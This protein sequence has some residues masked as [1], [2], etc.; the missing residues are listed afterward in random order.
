[1]SNSRH[2][3]LA[4]SGPSV[5]CVLFCLER[6][7]ENKSILQTDHE[8][9]YYIR[10]KWDSEWAVL[11]FVCMENEKGSNNGQERS[12]TS[13]S[14]RLDRIM[15]KLEE[16]NMLARARY[17]NGVTPIR[18]D[19]IAQIPISLL[20]GVG[21]SEKIPVESAEPEK[22]QETNPESWLQSFPMALAAEMWRAG[23][24]AR[25]VAA[26]LNKRGYVSARGVLITAGALTN[27]FRNRH[28]N[29]QGRPRYATSSEIVAFLDERTKDVTSEMRALIARVALEEI[30]EIKKS[31]KKKGWRIREEETKKGIEESVEVRSKRLADEIAHNARTW[32]PS[33]RGHPMSH[34]SEIRVSQIRTPLLQIRDVSVTTRVD[35]VTK[36]ESYS[37][38]GLDSVPLILTLRIVVITSTSKIDMDERSRLV[39]N[40]VLEILKGEVQKL[41]R[42]DASSFDWILSDDA[43]HKRVQIVRPSLMRNR[44]TVFIGDEVVEEF[45][46]STS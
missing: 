21:S 3:G 10:L 11:R 20:V 13:R 18:E 14:A 5:F 12:D 42:G 26:V 23:S 4:I 40:A 8:T 15:A 43:V 9:I 35:P 6:P 24:S 36:K 33:L 37:I 28:V 16:A 31:R 1:M 22:Q 46:P 45:P 2:E 25:M 44:Q 38:E 17:P 32:L 34:I 41:K 27:F 39:R 30:Q 19:M 29:D 7:D